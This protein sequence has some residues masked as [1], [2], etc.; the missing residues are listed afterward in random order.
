VWCF[1]VR[2]EAAEA[3]A[4]VNRPDETELANEL[5]AL[6]STHEQLKVREICSP[7]IGRCVVCQFE[8]KVVQIL[9]VK[10]CALDVEY[11]Q[12][13]S[14]VICLMHYAFCQ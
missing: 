7:C 11:H 4:K 14:L 10:F 9:D 8:F 6:H 12:F 2:C 1:A 5:S 3:K 13:S